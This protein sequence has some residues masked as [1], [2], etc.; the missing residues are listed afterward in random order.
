MCKTEVQQHNVE[1]TT[2][3]GTLIRTHKLVFMMGMLYTIVFVELPLRLIE[4]L[5]F[6]SNIYVKA[7]HFDITI[8]CRFGAQ[9]SENG[10]RIL[11]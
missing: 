2:I 10:D 8:V 5:I 7:V 1:K 9:Y 6:L 4:N 11:E 3:F